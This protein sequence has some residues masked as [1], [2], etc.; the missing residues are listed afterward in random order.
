MGGRAQVLGVH[1]QIRVE[2]LDAGA[3]REPRHLHVPRHCLDPAA[4]LPAG[5]EED[6]AEAEG[7][8]L[9]PREG[10]PEGRAGLEVGGKRSARE[11][12]LAVGPGCH[13]QAG[14][15]SSCEL[16]HRTYRLL[17]GLVTLSICRRSSQTIAHRSPHE[18]WY[19]IRWYVADSCV[20]PFCTSSDSLALFDRGSD[21]V[22]HA[23]K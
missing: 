12:Y 9:R 19:W 16:G 6:P 5:V 14:S 18:H 2:V 17:L 21:R 13:G 7:R 1:R 22:R 8:V 10:D 11:L 3:V 4:H 23:E 20:V 15:A